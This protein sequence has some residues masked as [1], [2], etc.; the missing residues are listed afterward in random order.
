MKKGLTSKIMKTLYEFK[1]N[2]EKEIEQTETSLNEK[3]E[4]IK[5][6]RK[7]KTFVP[8]RVAL[9]KPSRLTFDEAELFYGVKLSEGIKAGLLTKALLAKRFNNDGG[10]LS[11]VEQLEYSQ[12]YVDLFQLQT[13][14]QK[15]SLKDK[16][17]RSQEE[18]E[19]YQETIKKITYTRERIQNFEIA[20]AGLF[21]QTA[22]NRARNKTIIWWMLHL[23][24]IENEKGELESFF[25]EGDF[26]EKLKRYDFLEEEGDEFERSL[27]QKLIYLVSFWY[28]G[29]ASSQGEFEK[30]LSILESEPSKEDSK[31]EV[32]QEPKKEIASES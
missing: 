32:K 16:D 13:D 26:L 12:L 5:T 15:L 22:E 18:Q 9:K 25:S 30:L 7:V 4:E 6:V 28:M 11:E 1:A 3:N 2:R 8:T 17:I 19:K 14:F 20:Q 23:S 27:I 24:Y 31:E 10:V 29:R 21:D